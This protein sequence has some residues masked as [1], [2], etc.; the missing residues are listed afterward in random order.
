MHKINPS[1][2]FFI[3]SRTTYMY[4]SDLSLVA[5]EHKLPCQHAVHE[6]KNT[7]GGSMTLM[8]VMANDPEANCQ[9]HCKYQP[10]TR[11]N[12]RTTQYMLNQHITERDIHMIVR[13]DGCIGA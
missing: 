7:C 13:S 9:G 10:L 1:Y 6:A 2:L 4:S 12:K 3:A 11:N 8:H 5:I